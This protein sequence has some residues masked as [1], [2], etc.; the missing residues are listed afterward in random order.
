VVASCRQQ[1]R[2]LSVFLVA[3]GEAAL[4]DSPPPSLV[5]APQGG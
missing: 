4:R 3:A 2:P 1:G 5:L